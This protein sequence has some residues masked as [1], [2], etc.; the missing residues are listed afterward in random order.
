MS[1]D[2]ENWFKKHA[3]TVMILSAFA[4]CVL[5]INGKFNDI[6]K[7]ISI[8]RIE[9]ST[10]RSEVSIVKTV[11]LMKNILPSELTKNGEEKQ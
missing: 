6:D 1:H 7:E 8:L 3:D 10:I 4:A 9:I 5:W 2:Q 11:L